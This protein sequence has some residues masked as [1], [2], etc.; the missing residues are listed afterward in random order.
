MMQQVSLNREP[1]LCLLI[2][3]DLLL[4]VTATAILFGLWTVG[5]TQFKYSF[6]VHHYSLH[7]EAMLIPKNHRGGN[8]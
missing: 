8:C 7:L 5:Q 6:V 2:T 3:D 4:I 1:C